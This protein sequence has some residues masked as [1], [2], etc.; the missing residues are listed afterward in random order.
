LKRRFAWLALVLLVAAAAYA[1]WPRPTRQPLALQLHFT[2]DLR[3]RLVPCGCFTGQLG[4]LTR[5]ATVFGNG[6][7]PG[8][9]KLDVGDALEGTADYQRIEYRYILRAF[10]EIGYLAANMGHRE[11]ALSAAQLRELKSNSPVPMIS[12]NLLDAQTGAPL[13]ETH[14]IIEH[15]GWRIAV[16]GVLDPAGLAENLGEGLATEKM[17]TALAR[18]L[19]QLKGKA[20]AIVLLA[21]TDEPGLRRLARDF[22][23]VDVI[24]GGKVSQP[25]QRLERE[26][27]S[28]ILYVT[29]ESRAVG[30]FTARLAGP[31]RLEEAAGDVRLV[32]PRIAEAPA[33]LAL[34][35]AYRDEIRRA[36]LDLDDPQKLTADIVP[37][38]KAAASYSGTAACASCHGKASHAW[39][40]SG[41]AHAFSTLVAAK[42]D[43][44]PNCIGCHTVGF[45]SPTGYRREFGK[46]KLTNVGCESCHGPGSAHIAARQA[47]D[48][49]AGRMRKLGAGDCQKCH[50]GEFSRPFDWNEFWPAVKHGKEGSM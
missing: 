26:N 49:D 36:K 17:E 3:G 33:I 32:T 7:T 4:G 34:N 25:A 27:R 44:D 43:A 48:L 5:I 42:A 11:A 29:N 21:F 28:A 50:H 40:K 19:P 37:G 35:A 45:G 41:H 12:A 14:R 20:D 18:L 30:S 8:L 1:W 10:G 16:L 39:E 9:L 46:E 6:R 15:A 47:G 13:L 24:L 2:C 31:S 22:Y 38:V 23:E